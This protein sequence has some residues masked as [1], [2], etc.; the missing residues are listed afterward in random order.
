[1]T[2]RN[3]ASICNMVS[4]A[5]CARACVLLILLQPVKPEGVHM[6]VQLSPVIDR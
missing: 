5:C 3:I 4:K 2:V 6:R 1:M